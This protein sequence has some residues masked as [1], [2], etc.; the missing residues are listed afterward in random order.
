MQND[1]RSR[2]EKLEAVTRVDAPE[3]FSGMTEAEFV[4]NAIAAVQKVDGC[5]YEEAS[6]DPAIAAALMAFR[7]KQKTRKAADAPQGEEH[8][9]TGGPRP[10]RT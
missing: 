1:I 9:D 3:S 8:G 7:A 10:T 6:A 4:E 5:T 2:L